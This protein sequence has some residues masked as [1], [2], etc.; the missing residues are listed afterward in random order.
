MVKQNAHEVADLCLGR[1]CQSVTIDATQALKPTFD[2]HGPDVANIQTR[3][4]R[5]YPSREEFPIDHSS[6]QSMPSAS[7]RQLGFEVMVD[8]VAN[9]NPLLRLAV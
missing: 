2:G 6:C 9:R 5:S 3:P 1:V 8:Q 7:R 4:L